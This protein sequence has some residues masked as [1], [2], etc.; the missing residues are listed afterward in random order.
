MWAEDD[1]DLF[2]AMEKTRLCVYGANLEPEEPIVCN[3]YLAAFSSL[4]VTSVVLELS[5]A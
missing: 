1:P 5:L 2:V 4:K 3:G